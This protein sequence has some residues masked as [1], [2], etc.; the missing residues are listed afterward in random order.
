MDGVVGTDG[1]SQSA[2]AI[3]SN[4]GKELEP[5]SARLVWKRGLPVGPVDS[6]SESESVAGDDWLAGCS[7]QARA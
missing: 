7:W 6:D 4:A 2:T 5:G 1:D 3:S